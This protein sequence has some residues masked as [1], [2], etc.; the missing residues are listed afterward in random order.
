MR[1]VKFILQLLLGFALILIAVYSPLNEDG[2][3]AVGTAGFIVM[4]LTIIQDWQL[5]C[6]F[7]SIGRA[8]VS[9]TGCVRVVQDVLINGRVAE[10]V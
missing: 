10:S 7:S 9:K 1:N 6:I 8:P 2:R 3:V 5:K 4:F